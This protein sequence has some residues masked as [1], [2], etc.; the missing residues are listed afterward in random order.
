MIN[1]VQTPE[2]AL[3]APGEFRAGGTD[4]QERRRSG[5]SREA[6]VDLH[7]LAE[8]NQ[9][10]W[11]EQGAARIG[12][13]VTMATVARDA[14]IRQHYP[15]LAEAAGGLATPQIRTM[16]TMGGSLLQRTRCWY[17]R[18]PDVSCYK[19]GGDACPAREGNHQYGVC[20]DLGPCVFPHPSTLGMTLLAYEANVEIHGQGLQ[21]IADL[22]G[23]GSDPTRDHL[24]APGQLM[25]AI[26]LP[27]PLAGEQ[28]AYF[29]AISRAR[30][31]WPLVETTV[32]LVV[33]DQTMRVARV[34][35]GGVANIPLRLA[36]VE[37]ALVEQPP[38][39]QTLEQAAQRAVEG[40]N[41]LPLT[42]YKV[43]L[44]YGTV[45]ETLERAVR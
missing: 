5:V 27:P 45:L 34:A 26:H 8:L 32:L 4:F 43:D 2:E 30:A 36:K 13:G 38:T 12:A 37:A 42:G 24:L 10:E 22:Y 11:D 35:V 23:D 33:E 17:Y 28:S 19:K 39:A 15:A 20:F 7:A 1:L 3:A 21:S 40:V 14:A 25:T 29:R 16:G 41:P 44:L 6:I 31:E 9:I 18:H